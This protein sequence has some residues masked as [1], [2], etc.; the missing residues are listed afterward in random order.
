MTI[1]EIR[2]RKAAKVAEQRA[3]LAKAQSENRNL[4]TD[5]ARAFDALKSEVT[6]LEQAETR[7][8]FVDEAER[9]AAGVT[10]SNGNTDS[11]ASLEQRVSLLTILRAA[12][13]GRALTG[14]EAEM[15]AEL[16][17]RNGAA[18]HGG[19]LVP[20]SAFEARANTVAG[21]PDLVGTVHRGD[22]YIGPL[23]R[24]LL[25]RKLGVRT[26]SGLVG[27]V[28]IPKA[29]SGLTVGWVAEGGNVPESDMGFDAV[30]LSPKH[31][32]GVTEMSRQLIQ[33]SSPAIEDL[34]REDLSFAIASA[35][36]AAI[37]AGTGIGAIPKGLTART[38]ANGDV[39]T[40]DLPTT[41]ADVL[42][43]EQQLAAV[44][45]TPTGWYTSPGV[46]STLRGTLKSASAGSDYLATADK[47][48]DLPAAASNAAGLA[49]LAILGDWSQI[50]LGQWGDAVEI[51]V[52]PYAEAPYRRG[53]VL[54]RAFSTVDVAVRHEQAFVI[55]S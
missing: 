33:Q 34:V 18:K 9:R 46:M 26:L 10:V 29:G 22:L 40:A 20:L 36:D 38:G 14:P 48:G 49:G 4:S 39:Q 3:M 7:Q 13:E 5:E 2:Q 54:V 19:I 27:N 37:I 42:A 35:V 11:R 31:V 41:W 30:T 15:H 43:I 16:E 52:N 1:A 17:R 21:S 6:E 53:G 45:V 12:T 44:N 8:Q 32:G 25:V 47:V 55:A 23:R 51:L 28:S 24:S 50:L